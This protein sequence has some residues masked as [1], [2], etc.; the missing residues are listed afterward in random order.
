MRIKGTSISS[1]LAFLEEE[2]GG[3]RTRAFIES[4]DPALRRRCEGLVLASAFYPVAELESLATLARAHFAGDGTFFERSGAFNASFGLAGV[5][6][7]LL[8]RR[9]P[10]DFLRAGERSWSQ[11]TDTGGINI[12]QIGDGKVWI[13]VEGIPGS[14]VR[15]PRL[16]GFLSRG[17]DLAGAIQVSVRKTSCTLRRQ[18]YCEWTAAW[19]AE[20][21]PKPISYTTSIRRPGAT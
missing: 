5:Y 20:S 18:P 21:S 9:T 14:E 8:S 2:Y 4:L 11:F 13:R 10:L 3:A 17:L 7:A 1:L 19:D 6:Q 12:E 15:C 16:T